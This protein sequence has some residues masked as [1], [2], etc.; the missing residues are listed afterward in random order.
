MR[1]LQGGEHG[2][3]LAGT[4]RASFP[5]HTSALLKGVPSWPLSVRVPGICATGR[6]H[7]NVEDSSHQY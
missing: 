4:P 7:Y 3:M 6:Q 2:I 5:P 1:E